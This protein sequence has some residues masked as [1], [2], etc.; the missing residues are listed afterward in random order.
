MSPLQHYRVALEA[1]EFIPDEA[2]QLTLNRLAQLHSAL[3][4]TPIYKKGLKNF[5]SRL[6][7]HQTK[8]VPGLYLW[9]GVGRGKT[10]LLDL[11]YETLPFEQKLRL[12]FHRFM[13]LV[14]DELK[15][16]RHITQPLDIV[17]RHMA[18]KARVLC[19]DEMHVNDITD[20]MLMSGLLHGLFRRGVT[21]VSTSNIPPD[22]L[23]KDG[24][25]RASF[26]P[27]IELI[28]QHTQVVNLDGGIDYRLRTLERAEIYHT[29]LDELADACLE[30]N[31]HDLA[32]LEQRKLNFVLINNREIPV[33]R[34]TDGVAWFTFDT[35]CNTP[36][37]SSDYIE[38]ARFFHTVL[39]AG[40]PQMNKYCTDQA[41]RFVNMIDEFYDRNVK[42][43]CSAEVNPDDLYTGKRL[44]FEFERTASRLREMQSHEYLAR[45]HLP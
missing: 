7:G 1:C 39:V 13:Q 10:H 32:A 17:A 8:P 3:L 14:H 12:H 41:R 43:I 16:L 44:S 29:P 11:F 30:K 5:L 26:L 40:I 2:Q 25:Q 20:A 35:L 37:S 45:S 24:L 4:L 9:G 22:E 19:L 38:I 36:R 34:W 31:F 23:Y 27:A 18:A 21:L 28:K 15:D 6:R 33:V 42:L